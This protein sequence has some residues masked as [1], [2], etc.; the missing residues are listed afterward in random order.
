MRV[1]QQELVSRFVLISV[2]LA[3]VVLALFAGIKIAE[4]D[5]RQL[6]VI[7]AL[8]FTVVWSVMAG[9]R[10][11]VLFL[12][13]L[14]L[15]GHLHFGFKV[16]IYEIA[17]FVCLFPLILTIAMG[18]APLQWYRHSVPWFFHVM[19]IFLIMHMVGCFAYLSVESS[20]SFRSYG[21]VGRQYLQALW[22]FIFFYAYYYFGTPR[23]LN[24]ALTVLGI[25][26]LARMSLGYIQVWF[27]ALYYIP[28]INYVPSAS[29]WNDLRAS[30]PLVMALALGILPI[31][32]S[33]LVKT[34][35]VFLTA[36]ATIGT[37]FGGSRVALVSLALIPTLWCIFQRRFL[38]LFFSVTGMLSLVVFLNVQ[39][40]AI[41]QFPPTVQR[42][43]SALIFSEKRYDIEMDPS[44]SDR[45]HET[46]KRAGWEKWTESLSNFLI[47]AGFRP[48]NLDLE[49]DWSEGKVSFDEM[50]DQAK[51][52]NR[53]ESSLFAM[54]GAFGLIGLIFYMLVLYFLMKDIIPWLWRDGIISPAH[55]MAFIAVFLAARF[56][57]FIYHSGDVPSD[58]IL[59]ALLAH[60]ALNDRHRLSAAQKR[61]MEKIAQRNEQFIRTGSL[62]H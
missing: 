41:Y 33:N 53:F 49:F 51:T 44:L 10:W 21:S 16:R 6:A 9:S 25:V 54:T 5:F 61:N 32:R 52:T 48:F 11:W 60:T 2:L 45:W 47:G 15:G 42:A 4:N 1:S 56:L 35:F 29:G 59:Y 18:K 50:A 20:L 30:G 43:A 17:L 38:L 39:P 26:L 34:F 58:V 62:S 37:A 27:P 55:L 24:L 40:N 36:A 28:V 12:G 7:G 13:A 31:T 46:L 8:F 23:H 19:T 14:A 22:P 57:I 3:G